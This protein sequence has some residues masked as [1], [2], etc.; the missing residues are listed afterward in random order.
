MRLRAFALVA[1]MTIAFVGALAV[2]PAHAMFGG[3]QQ[4]A[5]GYTFHFFSDVDGVDVFSQHASAGVQ[6]GTNGTLSLQYVHD[7]VVIPAIEAPP[8]S[9]DAVDAITTASR[10]IANSG[11]PYEDFVKVRDE[12]I[13]S[14]TYYGIRGSYYVSTESDYFAQ[15]VTL[16]I[17]QGFFNDNTTLTLGASYGWDEITPLADFDTQGVPDQQTTVHGHMVITQ[18]V[19]PTTV[20]RL[21]AEFNNVVGLQHD[22]YRNVYVAGTNVPELHPNRRERRTVFTRVSQYINNRSSVKVDYR[23]YTDDWGVESHTIGGNLSQYVTDHLVI[24]YRYRYYTQL[25]SFFYRGEYEQSG[26][27]GGFQTNDYRLGD[28]GAHLFGGQL[29]WRLNSVVS[30]RYLAST[31]LIF[32]YEHYFN[33]NNFSANVYEAGF[34]WTF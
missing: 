11:D 32:R 17:S 2:A 1:V 9:Q 19:T 16:E 14:A 22:P 26:G 12:L 20:F 33:S 28:Y 4:P 31:N 7:V 6:F 3:L 8:G 34:R 27:V 10:P 18:V 13:A 25:P 15:M 29:L 23:Y 30:W 5:V 21:G 24:R